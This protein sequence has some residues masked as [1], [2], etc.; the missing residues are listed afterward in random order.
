MLCTPEVCFDE[1][2]YGLNGQK[3]EKQNYATQ[4]LEGG[5]QWSSIC[6]KP[7]CKISWQSDE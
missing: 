7:A 1:D 5:S 4:S 3:Y 2:I 6:Q